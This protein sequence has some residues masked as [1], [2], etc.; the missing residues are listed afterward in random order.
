MIDLDRSEIEVSEDWRCVILCCAE[1]AK[2]DAARIL[3]ALE[4]RFPYLY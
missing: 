2:M 1:R 3:G 4:V